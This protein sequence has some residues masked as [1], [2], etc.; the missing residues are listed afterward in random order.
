MPHPHWGTITKIYSASPN[1]GHHDLYG[2]PFVGT[3][4][5]SAASRPICGAQEGL[6]DQPLQ[7][8]SGSAEKLCSASPSKGV[9]LH[10]PSSLPPWPLS[11]P[12][13][14]VPSPGHNP[15]QLSS[16]PPEAYTASASSQPGWDIPAQHSQPGSWP[17]STLQRG[18]RPCPT[19]GPTPTGLAGAA[20]WEPWE[21]LL[22]PAPPGGR[23]A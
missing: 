16:G 1:K 3:L 5:S 19:R 17:G 4:F 14:W 15:R 2:E 20:A 22:A 9:S 8:L 18:C 13:V 23:S 7:L 11:H 21:L 6:R 12:A 10:L